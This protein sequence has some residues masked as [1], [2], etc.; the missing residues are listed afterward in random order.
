MQRQQPYQPQLQQEYYYQRRQDIKPWRPQ[1]ECSQKQWSG[2]HVLAMA[3]AKD[4]AVGSVLATMVLD[5]DIGEV[6]MVGGGDMG[7]VVMGEVV[8]GE[9]VM[10]GAMVMVGM[11][12]GEGEGEGEVG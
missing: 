4:S 11:V 7:E 1:Q 2:H 3:V 10:V 9:V 5:K 6:G 12:L 8:M